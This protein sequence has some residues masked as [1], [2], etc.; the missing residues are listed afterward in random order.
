[1]LG[2]H[3]PRE[4]QPRIREG[5]HQLGRDERHITGADEHGPTVGQAERLH[6]SDERMARCLRLDP[7]V[8][9][10]QAGKLGIG[11]GDDRYLA[12]N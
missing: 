8:H 10:G 1:M 9:P 2:D 4:T 5:P 12:Q 7:H 3:R 6:D 11:L